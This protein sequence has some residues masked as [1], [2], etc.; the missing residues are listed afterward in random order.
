[1]H[2]FEGG[3]SAGTALAN[4][5]LGTTDRAPGG[6]MPWTTYPDQC[7]FPSPPA[8]RLPRTFSPGSGVFLLPVL[9]CK[10]PQ[11]LRPYE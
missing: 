1:M 6:V 7:A 10:L 11:H 5:L 2:G 3:Q 4:M 8:P 9:R